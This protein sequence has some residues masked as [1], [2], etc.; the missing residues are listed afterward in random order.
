M[1]FDYDD[2]QHIKDGSAHI[3][4]INVKPALLTQFKS[5]GYMLGVKVCLNSHLLGSLKSLELFQALN[6][7]II[8]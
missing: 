6:K 2:F 5:E 1:F 4:T 8:G 7:N 3:L